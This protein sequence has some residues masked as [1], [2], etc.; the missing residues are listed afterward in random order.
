M[1]I[2]KRYIL[3]ND[4]KMIG[5]ENLKFTRNRSLKKIYLSADYRSEI[6]K[7]E[8][9]ITFDVSLDE[10]KNGK[11]DMVNLCR[12]ML[13]TFENFKNMKA[14]DQKKYAE[15]HGRKLINE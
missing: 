12:E 3:R 13:N 15:E 11:L 10:F 2:N 6:G 5:L 1:M 7:S 4:L 9:L 14:T 8:Y